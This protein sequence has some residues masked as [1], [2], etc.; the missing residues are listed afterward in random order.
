M[1]ARRS[2]Y[3]LGGG[4]LSRAA[5]DGRAAENEED[6]ARIPREHAGGRSLSRPRSVV[7][8]G[9]PGRSSRGKVE[10]RRNEFRYRLGCWPSERSAPECF[11]DVPFRAGQNHSRIV[12]ARVARVCR[13]WKKAGAAAQGKTRLLVFA[14]VTTRECRP[15]ST[16]S[17]VDFCNF[18][19]VGSYFTSK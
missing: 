15:R 12:V 10:H 11:R 3:R 8:V 17:L 16:R 4:V 13:R 18:P 6:L 7:H 9:Q 5:R 14:R 2:E 1:R 19:C